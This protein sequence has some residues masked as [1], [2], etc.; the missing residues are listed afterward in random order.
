MGCG[1]GWGVDR[2]AGRR[3]DC[4]EQSEVI[5]DSRA[6]PGLHMTLKRPMGLDFVSFTTLQ[7]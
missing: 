3:P 5:S 6:E 2:L 7:F 1:T 4:L